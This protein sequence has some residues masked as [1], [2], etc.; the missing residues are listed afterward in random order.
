MKQLLTPEGREWLKAQH[1]DK[2]KGFI[3]YQQGWQDSD[4]GATVDDAF[5][6]TDVLGIGAAVPA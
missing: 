3:V 2:L 1:P 6:L 5:I 4:E